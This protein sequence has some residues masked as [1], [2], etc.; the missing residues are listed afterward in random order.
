MRSDYSGNGVGVLKIFEL[1]CGLLKSTQS[2][3]TGQYG[4]LART[5]SRRMGAPRPPWHSRQYVLLLCVVWD[6]VLEFR[7]QA[8]SSRCRA[9]GSSMGRILAPFAEQAALAVDG[10]CTCSCSPR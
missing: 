9:L 6:K 3:S 7:P 8:R 10:T 2:N 1:D 5:L 4:P